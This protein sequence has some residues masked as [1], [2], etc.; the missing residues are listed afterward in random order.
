MNWKKL[1]ETKNAKTFVLPE[2]WDSREAIANDLECSPEKVRDHLRP[3]LASKEVIERRFSVW[4]AELKRC[5]MVTAY[6]QV[7]SP[8][9]VSPSEFD[10][11]RAQELKKEGKSYAE[12]GAALGGLSG[13]KV[14]SRLRRA[15]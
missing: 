11:A 9:A 12:I 7:S 1:V 6:R 13:E 2:G 10:V 15:G 4:D 14:R 8:V 5:V 3:A